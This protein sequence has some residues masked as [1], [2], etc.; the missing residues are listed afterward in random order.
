MYGIYAEIKFY[1][2]PR[3][4]FIVQERE[5]AHACDIQCISLS[6][7]NFEIFLCLVYAVK[8][9]NSNKLLKHQDI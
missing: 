4:Q 3:N 9:G 6:I 8:V 1:E 2:V 7:C 5:R